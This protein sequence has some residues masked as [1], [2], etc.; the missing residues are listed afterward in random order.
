[1]SR[2]SHPLSQA[3]L[4]TLAASVTA[5]VVFLGLS[6]V[7]LESV[8]VLFK[9]GVVTVAV[10]SFVKPTDGLLVVAGLSSLGLVAGR[11]LESPTR[12][13]EAIV[14]AFLAGWFLRLWR[15]PSRFS[16]DLGNL[17]SPAIL[18]GLVLLASCIEQL[19][20]L[21]VQTDYPWPFTQRVA[22]YL[23]DGYL[24]APS[25][26]NMLLQ[27]VR[28]IEGLGLL[29]AVVLLSRGDENLPRRLT[30]MLV[31]GAVGAAAINVA[32][33]VTELLSTGDWVGE[34]GNYFYANRSTTFIGD[35]N[36]AGSYLGMMALVTIGY[37]WTRR[38]RLLGWMGGGLLLMALSLSGSRAAA[39]ATLPVLVCLI[40]WRVF[41][42]FVLARRAVQGVVLIALF[43]VAGVLTALYL[44]SLVAAPRDMMSALKIRWGL[45]QTSFD[46]WSSRPFFGVGVGQYELWSLHFLPPELLA[47][48]D[49]VNGTTITEYS[50]FIHIILEG[51]PLRVNAHNQFLQIAAELGS[52]GLGVFLWLLGAVTRRIWFLVRTG[53]DRRIMAGV[54]A[55]L[56]AFL[57]SSL[58]GHP[59]LVPE[60]TY[61][62]WL[63]LGIAVASGREDSQL[64][65]LKHGPSESTAMDQPSR[66]RSFW[67][68]S[69]EDRFVAGVA[70]LLLLSLPGR[71]NSELRQIDLEDVAYG[72]HAWEDEADGTPFRWTTGRTRVFLSSDT[73]TVDIPLRAMLLPGVEQFDISITLPGC[74]S[75]TIQLSDDAWHQYRLWLP[76]RGQ[77]RHRR[78]DATVRQ[79]WFPSQAIPGSSDPR[80]LGVKSGAIQTS[81]T[82]DDLIR[83]QPCTVQEVTP[84]TAS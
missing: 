56:V 46:M 70:V 5:M 72:F 42:S 32:V 79:T 82:V 37:V 76:E 14:L 80:E 16:R 69:S 10:L 22:R 6:P 20:F 29:S 25:G 74:P 75:L 35:P 40:A 52:I 61:P 19:V 48:V 7:L 67:S 83:L 57:V 51:G 28:F 30:K 26:M 58:G 4:F 31:V 66:N 55:G 33:P 1:M 41:P 47:G 78:L 50:P 27:T 24:I 8:S 43:A 65:L 11:L 71:V 2:V 73:Q 62:F 59:F 12:G 9:L 36:A 68:F 18:F 44:D 64:D 23:K 38:W 45:A 34:F 84:L 77:G 63:L 17:Y 21:Q 15:T 60:V 54:V 49:D 81:R 3:L 53:Y 13:S 39:V